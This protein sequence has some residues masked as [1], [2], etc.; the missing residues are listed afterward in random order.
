[1]GEGITLHRAMTASY[2]HRQ[3]A[4]EEVASTEVVY[5]SSSWASSGLCAPWEART[6]LPRAQRPARHAVFE[7]EI[8]GHGKAFRRFRLADRSA[9]EAPP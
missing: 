2:A 5:E 6:V 8:E 1:M 7:A 9:K 3:E 4:A